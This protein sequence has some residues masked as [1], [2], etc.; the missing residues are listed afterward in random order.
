MSH[1]YFMI[2]D[3]IYS[4]EDKNSDL[5]IMRYFDLAIIPAEGAFCITIS[6]DEDVHYSNKIIIL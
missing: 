5:S 1:I 2:S 4:G 6:P 3:S